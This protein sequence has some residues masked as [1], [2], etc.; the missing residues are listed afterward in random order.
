MRSVNIHEAKTQF[1]QL[2]EAVLWGQETLIAKAGKPVAKLC[3]LTKRKAKFKFGVLKG[4]IKIAQNFDEA[5]PEDILSDF[6][7]G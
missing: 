5:L 4:K 2:V 6:E 3:P 7:G 1:S